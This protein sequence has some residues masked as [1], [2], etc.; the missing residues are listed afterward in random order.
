[1]NWFHYGSQSV[2]RLSYS[3]EIWAALIWFV[4][5]TLFLIN[6]YFL[7]LS[8]KSLS[9]YTTAADSFRL[10]GALTCLISGNLITFLFGWSFILY[11]QFLFLSNP[12]DIRN[13]LSDR[14]SIFNAQKVFI[15]SFAGDLLFIFG[16]LGLSGG[17]FHNAFSDIAIEGASSFYLSL[18]VAGACVRM[19]SVPFLHLIKNNNPSSYEGVFS[20]V[21]STLLTAPVLF[22][23]IGPQIHS[24]P[25]LEFYSA[26]SSLAA[27]FA[28]LRA[29]EES[30]LYKSLSWVTA[31]VVNVAVSM[32][33]LGF[34]ANNLLYVLVSTISI[35]LILITTEYL[36]PK[37]TASKMF[38]AMAGTSFVAPV[39]FMNAQANLHN[40]S[41]LLILGQERRLAWIILGLFMM[42]NILL[43]IFGVRMIRGNIFNLSSIGRKATNVGIIYS[44]PMVALSLL[45]LSIVSGGMVFSGWIGPIELEI[46]SWT[47]WL[48]NAI[49]ESSVIFKTQPKDDELDF[50]GRIISYGSVLISLAVG[51]IGFERDTSAHKK[52]IAFWMRLSR[53]TKLDELL[54]RLIWQYF[55]QKAVG[56]LSKSIVNS[57]II[58]SKVVERFVTAT[59]QSVSRI[60]TMYIER[61]TQYVIVNGTEN[62]FRVVS[63]GVRS[64]HREKLFYAITLAMIISSAAIVRFFFLGVN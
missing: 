49:N 25:A 27:I 58:I 56:R 23:K 4:L 32:L 7:L 64:A 43:G 62:V 40:Y 5:S 37:S 33:L 11:G 31:S 8:G 2:F 29:L 42:T 41:N 46:A 30:D 10:F 6:D 35:Y 47:N 12:E 60:A 51:L 3:L 1:M 9:R 16:A 20:L 24:V 22:L 50:L 38:L 13:Q 63:E 26:A 53:F 28:V 17:F 48:I 61:A 45:V 39:L 15:Y 36:A 55:G 57:E 14:N 52:S 19:H 18:L 34:D 59:A 44:L 21:Y 54:D